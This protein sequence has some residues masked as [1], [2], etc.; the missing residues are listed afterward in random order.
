MTTST[1][2]TRLLNPDRS[3]RRLTTH[4]ADS[5]RFDR[6]MTLLATLFV[7]G[8]YVDGWAHN[9][10]LELIET[11]F[12]PWHGM[13]YG[14]FAL[15]AAA[16]VLTLAFNLFRG[17]SW[18]FALPR[19]YAPGILGILIF[20][21]SGVL[22]LVWHETFGFEDGTEALLSP[23]HLLLASGAILMLA[24]PLRAAW[25]R[26]DGTEIPGW[27]E[28]LPALVSAT[29][30]LAILSFFMQ[31]AT[32]ARPG[33]LIHAPKGS[34]P[35]YQAD[36]AAIFNL[37]APSLLIMGS[38]LFLLRRWRLPLGSFTLII[39]LSYT[40]M[41]LM[42]MQDSFVAP[43]SWVGVMLASV[44]VDLLYARLQ[45][46]AEREVAMRWF[47]FLLPFI[48]IGLHMATLLLTHGL[49]W[50]VHM[51]AGAPFICG[52]LGLFLSFVAFPPQVPGQQAVGQ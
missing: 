51:W 30:V 16:L 9:N 29:L 11:F 23:T 10:I 38:V 42:T 39:G 20:A 36:S 2:S 47:A 13:L 31:Y 22:D 43:W 41:F 32:F 48:L 8:I 46:S 44:L 34:G 27:R 37:F 28:L 3:Q 45:P 33:A 18:Q 35:T 21:V 4:P 7:F 17:Y 12:T 40:L 49:W 15:L 6:W 25:Q 26:V 50:Q 19:G 52:V 24:G 14:G 1:Q 5:L